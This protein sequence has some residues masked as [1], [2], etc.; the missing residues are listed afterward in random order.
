MKKKVTILLLAFCL[1]FLAAC[2][3]PSPSDALKADLENAKSSPDEIMDGLGSDG[4]GEEA[5]QALIDKVLEFDYELGEET[6]DGDTATVE[7]TITTYPFGEMFS[8]LLISFMGEALADPTMTEETM[9]DTLD[10]LLIES[11]D[12]AEKTYEATV[13]VT[14]I[15]DGDAWVVQESDELSNALTGGMLDFANSAS[16]LS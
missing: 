6:I 14:L 1:V 7:A 12:S 4:F 11:L 9:M 13:T 8:N 16:S 3:S 10:Q 5:T 2:G 15:N